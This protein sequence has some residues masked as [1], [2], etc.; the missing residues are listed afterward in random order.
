MT[1]QSLPREYR[2]TSGR[3]LRAQGIL[4][5][6]AVAVLLVVW[7][8][9][10]FTPWVNLLVTVLVLAFFGRLTYGARRAGT[11]VDVRG[12]RIRTLFR[13]RRLAWAE[14]G[15]IRAEANPSSAPAPHAPRVLTYAYRADGRRRVELAFV[16]DVHVDV[17]RE[18]AVLR[19]AW[20][21]L[22]GDGGTG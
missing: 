21:E 4:G 22:R 13:E 7:N 9:D 1:T 15:D 20:T 3:L 11:T 12:V 18:V 17:A 5:G 8:G 19:E 2:I 16:D 6:G 10:A 14:I